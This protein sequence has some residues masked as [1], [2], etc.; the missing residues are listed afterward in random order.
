MAIRVFCR[1]FLFLIIIVMNFVIAIVSDVVIVNVYIVVV[2]VVV[3]N[4]VVGSCVFVFVLCLKSVEGG[5]Y[6]SR[7]R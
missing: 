6:G 5:Y 1:F 3:V 4:D 2:I 7:N